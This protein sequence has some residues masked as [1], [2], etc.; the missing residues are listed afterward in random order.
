MNSILLRNRE[1]DETMLV[2]RLA[3]GRILITHSELDGPGEFEE[4]RFS[5]QGQPSSGRLQIGSE[6]YALTLEETRQVR[7]AIARLQDEDEE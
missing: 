7:A 4:G 1:D 2:K 6:H 5:F 3:D